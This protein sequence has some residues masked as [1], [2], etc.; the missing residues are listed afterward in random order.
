VDMNFAVIKT[1]GK[2]YKVAEGDIL[3]VEKLDNFK[4]GGKM[5]F[6]E[7]L[8]VAGDKETKIGEPL[9]A[10]AKVEAEFLEE[11]KAKKLLVLRFKS[12]SNYHKIKGHRQPYTKLKISKISV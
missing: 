9:V 6:E 4:E 1:G 5:T 11:G 7:V 10:G 12:K 2:Q 3:K 8:L